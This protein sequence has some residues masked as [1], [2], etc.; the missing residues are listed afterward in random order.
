MKKIKEALTKSENKY[1]SL[2]EDSADGI[3]VVNEQS[4]ILE[5]NNKICEILDY[6]KEEL[7]LINAN[8]IIHSDDRR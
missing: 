4:N 7:I 8:D 3:F 5:L 2:F 6:S 1:K